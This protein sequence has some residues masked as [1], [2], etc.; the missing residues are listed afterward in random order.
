MSPL[1]AELTDEVKLELAAEFAELRRRYP[2]IRFERLGDHM[3]M[4]P[5]RQI[6]PWQVNRRQW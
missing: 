2:P 3:F 1:T 4:R 5:L 6:R